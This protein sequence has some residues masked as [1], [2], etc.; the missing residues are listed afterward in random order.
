VEATVE[1]MTTERAGTPEP[2]GGERPALPR[3]LQALV[4]ALQGP[5]DLGVNHDAY[6]CYPAGEDSSGGAASA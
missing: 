1:A 3:H 5:A 4:G 6:L 2:D